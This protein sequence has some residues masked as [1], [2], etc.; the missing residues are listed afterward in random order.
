M[1]TADRLPLDKGGSKLMNKHTS[2]TPMHTDTTPLPFHIKTGNSLVI[3]NDVV[4]IFQKILMFIQMSEISSQVQLFR[5]N[6]MINRMI[7]IISH[8]QSH[9]LF[10]MLNLLYNRIHAPQKIK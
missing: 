1:Y 7:N 9:R 6:V 8:I 4:L 10:L 5:Q 2:I 3:T